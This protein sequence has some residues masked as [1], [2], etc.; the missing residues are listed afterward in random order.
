MR[1]VFTKEELQGYACFDRGIDG[2]MAKTILAE[3]AEREKNPGV[4]DG[5][6]EWADRVRV[7][8]SSSSGKSYPYSGA[9]TY[10]RTL[11]KTKAREIAEKAGREFPSNDGFI[12]MDRK[13]LAEVVL[14]AINEALAGGGK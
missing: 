8:Y 11:P 6:P 14:N 9:K 13:T 10:T 2:D 7:E 4:W 12:T 5:A 3:R 1:R